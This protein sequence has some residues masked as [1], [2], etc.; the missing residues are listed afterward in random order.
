[1]A[2]S[3][4]ERPEDSLMGFREDTSELSTTLNSH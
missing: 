4:K 2:I 1:M 3:I